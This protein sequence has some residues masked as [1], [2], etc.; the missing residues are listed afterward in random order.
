MAYDDDDDENKGAE[1][2]AV[3]TTAMAF[4]ALFGSSPFGEDDDDAD[5]ASDDKSADSKDSS[6]ARKDSTSAAKLDDSHNQVTTLSADAVAAAREQLKEASVRQAAE[7][8]SKLAAAQTKGA[9]VVWRNL[10]FIDSQKKK[11][12]KGGT[13]FKQST[14]KFWQAT[15]KRRANQ[16]ASEKAM[17]AEAEAIAARENAEAVAAINAEAAKRNDNVATTA[18]AAARFGALLNSIKATKERKRR[19]KVAQA[20][21]SGTRIETPNLFAIDDKV[22]KLVRRI[23]SFDHVIGQLAQILGVDLSPALAEAMATLPSDHKWPDDTASNDADS[24]KPLSPSDL[25]QRLTTAATQLQA[26]ATVLSRFPATHDIL[27]FEEESLTFLTADDLDIDS[28]EEEEDWDWEDD[29]EPEAESA[30]KDAAASIDSPDSTA[31]AVAAPADADAASDA[32]AAATAAEDSTAPAA[33]AAEDKSTGK[34]RGRRKAKTTKAKTTK[35]KGR[36]KAA[37]KAAETKAPDYDDDEAFFAS[38]ENSNFKEPEQLNTVLMTKRVAA[39]CDVVIAQE[40]ALI[41]L[42]VASPET[43][44]RL[45]VPKM[46][47]PRD[48]GAAAAGQEGAVSDAL[49][50][51]MHHDEEAFET[52][53]AQIINEPPIANPSKRGRPKGSRNRKTLERIARAAAAKEGLYFEDAIFKRLMSVKEAAAEEYRRNKLRKRTRDRYVSKINKEAL[54][55]QEELMR[56]PKFMAALE[57]Y[58]GGADKGAEETSLW[59][60]NPNTL[61][62]DLS[63]SSA[64]KPAVLLP[65]AL[66]PVHHDDDD[67]DDEEVEAKTQSKGKRKTKIKAPTAAEVADAA[68]VAAGIQL[69]AKDKAAEEKPKVAPA[70]LR[71]MATEALFAPVTTPIEQENQE[72]AMARQRAHLITRIARRRRRKSKQDIMEQQSLQAVS[73]QPFVD[74]DKIDV[75][76]VDDAN[77]AKGVTV[78][79]A[80]TRPGFEE[81]VAE[82]IAKQQSA[83]RKKPQAVKAATKEPEKRPDPE[84]LLKAAALMQAVHEAKAEQKAKEAAQRAEQEAKASA[85]AAAAAKAEVEDDAE[86]YDYDPRN[87]PDYDPRY[88]WENRSYADQYQYYDEDED[89]EAVAEEA[90]AKEAEAEADP[91]PEQPVQRQTRAAK[92]KPAPELSAAAVRPRKTKKVTRRKAVKKAEPAPVPEV[93]SPMSRV[94]AAQ[95]QVDMGAGVASLVSAPESQDKTPVEATGTEE[96]A[97]PAAAE[98]VAKAKSKAKAKTA[99]KASPKAAPKAKVTA[100]AKATPKTRAQAK[101]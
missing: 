21:R 94:I 101:S 13:R 10:E 37:D 58:E 22:N 73:T 8:Q 77:S 59:D 19:A 41:M 82:A 1:G 84:A 51:T 66:A 14:F 69:P 7:E 91:E 92:V 49:P 23:K 71:A 27:S 78:L 25:H 67:E 36:T 61:V 72:H 40:Q 53:V 16:T 24:L 9:Y 5:S 45:P 26:I 79:R 44:R 28:T 93:V 38:F 96:S 60:E 2:K 76:V 29:E 65:P 50:V 3:V 70:K 31:S 68:A 46:A 74:P 47:L 33:A 43:L 86:L 52:L 88:D 39:V 55:T 89:E 64:P 17:I 98:T 75:E 62:S 11:N 97:T 30:L 100:K 83:R 63:R 12:K 56:D 95:V 20:L 90:E 18:T 87:D 32:S 54:L 81:E 34:G 99:A 42:L 48:K 4:A 6:A 35:A 15:P 57:K 85:A 80:S